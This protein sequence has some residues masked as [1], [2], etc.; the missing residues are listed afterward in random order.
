MASLWPRWLFLITSWRINTFY[1][2]CRPLIW[3]KFKR[4]VRQTA[5]MIIFPQSIIIIYLF[6]GPVC[7][8]W[9][10]L[11][12][13]I[14]IANERKCKKM[15]TLSVHANVHSELSSVKMSGTANPETT[16]PPGTCKSVFGNILDIRRNRGMSRTVNLVYLHNPKFG[17][18]LPCGP[19]V[20]VNLNACFYCL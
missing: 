5:D 1:I 11:V 2:D 4:I 7:K 15:L 14:L 8:T 6:I 18:L 9:C 3:L 20:Y 17:H 10:H 13:R 12:V 16:D 19:A